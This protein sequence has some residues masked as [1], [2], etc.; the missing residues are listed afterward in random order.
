MSRAHRVQ[1][2]ARLTGMRLVAMPGGEQIP[3]GKMS[4]SRERHRDRRREQQLE[5][6]NSYRPWVVVSQVAMVV[7]MY[8]SGR[9]GLRRDTSVS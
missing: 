2:V 1:V 6:T 8:D 4:G 3:C 9:R 7:S 5:L